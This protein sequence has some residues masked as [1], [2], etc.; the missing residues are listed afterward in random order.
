ME[1]SL[2]LAKFW[3]WYLI[4]F[5]IILSFNPKRIKQI[6]EFLKDQKFAVLASFLAIIV[7]LINILL[8]NIWEAN[9]TIIVT[10]LGWAALL[11]GVIM[12]IFPQK[13]VKSIEFIN[14][15]LV[16]AVYIFFFM[17]GLYLLNMGYELIPYEGY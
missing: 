16:Q 5:F 1:V 12:F 2:F 10:L 6:F 4:I 7:G 15:K 3:G 11:K 14:I 8:H 17:C 13:A 9:W